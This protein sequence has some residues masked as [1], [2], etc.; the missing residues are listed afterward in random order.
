MS[1]APGARVV[2]ARV[3]WALFLPLATLTEA[4]GV[5]LLWTGHGIGWA[6]VLAP[7]PGMPG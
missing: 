4:G 5:L 1:Q 6:A 7:I 2:N 3:P